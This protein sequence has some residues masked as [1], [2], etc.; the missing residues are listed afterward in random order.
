[1][2]NNEGVV[3]FSLPTLASDII[4]PVIEIFLK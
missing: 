4:D 3:V 2:D 1:M